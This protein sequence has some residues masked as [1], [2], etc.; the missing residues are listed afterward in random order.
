MPCTL[1]KLGLRVSG[2]SK[3]MRTPKQV[4]SPSA[5]MPGPVPC[6][7]RIPPP[8][9]FVTARLQPCEAGTHIMVV[10]PVLGK[11]VHDKRLDHWALLGRSGCVVEDDALC[12]LVAT[13]RHFLLKWRMHWMQSRCGIA[14]IS[15]HNH[16][17]I[18]QFQCCHLG[19][20]LHRNRARVSGR[21]ARNLHKDE[22]G[23]CRSGGAGRPVATPLRD[24]LRKTARVA[25]GIAAVRFTLVPQPRPH[26]SPEKGVD[27]AVVE[28]RMRFRVGRGRHFLQIRQPWIGVGGG[29]GRSC[30]LGAFATGLQGLGR[31]PYLDGRA[32]PACCNQAYGHA[33]AVGKHFLAKVV[34]HR[35]HARD[36]GAGGHRPFD[37]RAEIQLRLGGVG[38][39][40]FLRHLQ[41]AQSFLSPLGRIGNLL[42]R[43]QR[44]DNL[45]LHVALSAAQKHVAKQHA[46]D[47][48]GLALGVGDGQSVSSGRGRCAGQSHLP[49]P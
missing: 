23:V 41:N 10:A 36:G 47:G 16:A 28:H 48:K 49:S 9:V 18:V 20:A 42:R 40:S 2:W 43:V 38:I 7:T 6:H 35:A 37:A 11:L 17:D 27:H 22:G 34:A 26:W 8:P 21:P 5:Q 30:R 39:R 4:N 32:S 15:G 46:V 25:H 33:W 13:T 44:V 24:H 29:S 1:P 14:N 12:N 45:Q 3:V 31:H 19:V